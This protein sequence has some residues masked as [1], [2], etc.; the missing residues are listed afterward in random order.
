MVFAHLPLEVTDGDDGVD[1]DK[2]H[3]DDE[4]NP[5]EIEMDGDDEVVTP[6]IGHEHPGNG[7]GAAEDPEAVHVGSANGDGEGHEKCEGER[8]EDKEA[9]HAR[10]A[11]GAGKGG[12]GR[13]W[14]MASWSPLNWS[15]PKISFKYLC[16]SF[17]IHNISR[18][19]ALYSFT[20]IVKK[21]ELVEKII[22]FF[23]YI[24]PNRL[25]YNTL[26]R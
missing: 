16:K 17:I 15:K 1:G 9:R 25:L 11:L 5:I 3:F 20:K 13:L 18:N 26:T 7:V 6:G 4:D 22:V 2:R 19:N 24:F 12:D 10:N 23:Q 8:G 21:N 14:M